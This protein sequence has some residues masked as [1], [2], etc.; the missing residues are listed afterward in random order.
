MDQKGFVIPPHAEVP[1]DADAFQSISILLRKSHTIEL[2]FWTST[3]AASFFPITNHSV[4]V[5]LDTIKSSVL[6][7]EVSNS[8]F[9]FVL[10]QTDNLSLFA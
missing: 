8:S 2:S 7:C 9:A 3:E 10:N 6:I 5:G 4:S 1:S